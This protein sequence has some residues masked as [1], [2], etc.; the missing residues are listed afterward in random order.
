MEMYNNRIQIFSNNYS[1]KSQ[2]GMSTLKHPTD[3]QLTK[4]TIFVLSY[5]NPFLYSFNYDLTQLHNTVCDSICRYLAGPYSFII[6]I[7]ELLIFILSYYIPIYLYVHGL[8]VLLYYLFPKLNN[9]CLVQ[10]N[11]YKWEYQ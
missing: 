6:V 7:A 5:Q 3:I 9:L 1:Y 4:D 11:L 8:H 10:C 2:F